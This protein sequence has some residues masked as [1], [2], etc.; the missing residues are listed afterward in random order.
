MVWSATLV[1]MSE[2]SRFTPRPFPLWW[3]TRHAWKERLAELNGSIP[4]LAAEILGRTSIRMSVQQNGQELQPD[5]YP[6]KDPTRGTLLVGCHRGGN[7]PAFLAALLGEAGNKP[8]RAFAKPYAFLA[9]G[10][11]QLAQRPDGS[12]DDRVAST[13]L[14]VVSQ[15]LAND[16]GPAVSMQRLFWWA[17]MRR[18]LP[19]FAEIQANTNRVFD[20][21]SAALRNG[22]A[23]LIFPTGQ[24]ADALTTKWRPGVGRLVAECRDFAENVDIVPFR[25]GE[26][27][28]L[29][30]ARAVMFGGRSP[31]EQVD[32][33]LASTYTAEEL[34]TSAESTGNRLGYLA[35]MTEIQNRYIEHFN[36]AC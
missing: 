1:G 19:S 29:R 30:I 25:F 10:L 35:L 11:A 12:I 9:Q 23:M 6:W 16:T 27:H 26:Y 2:T 22:E 31:D 36:Q 32:I 7:E 33:H 17:G 24:V 14:P 5:Q 3:P 8:L 15:R 21:A 20:Q 13:L 4:K 34:I 28:P 18:R